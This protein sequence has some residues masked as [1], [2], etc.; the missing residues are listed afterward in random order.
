MTNVWYAVTILQAQLQSAEASA[1]AADKSAAALQQQAL[2]WRS[3]MKK[4][5]ADI[6]SLTAKVC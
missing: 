3:R 4:K 6:A 1:E 5:D 2:T